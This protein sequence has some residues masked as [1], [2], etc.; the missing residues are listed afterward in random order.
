V[1]GFRDDMA[2]DLGAVFYNTDEFAVDG[3]YNNGVQDTDITLI[4]D[5]D[6]DGSGSPG[7]TAEAWVKKTQVPSPEYRQTIT[8][9]G[10]TWTIDQEKGRAGYKHDGLNW[11]LPL[12]RERRSTQWRR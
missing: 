1:A 5:A 7:A 8:V 12:I 6:A 3:V 11:H 10:T 9:D 4:L 2:T